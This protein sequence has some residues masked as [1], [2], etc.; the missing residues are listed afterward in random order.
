[1]GRKGRSALLSPF[2]WKKANTIINRLY[3]PVPRLPTVEK[4]KVF[5]PL[6]YYG[7]VSDK[8]R[9]ALTKLVTEY[10]P[11]INLHLAF[12]NRNTI[13]SF[14]QIKNPI[15]LMQRSRVVYKYTCG[16]CSDTYIGKT[17][18]RLATRV[19]E[20]RGI[21]DRTDKPLA[22]PPFSAIREHM[23]QH[24]V[25]VDP[26]C[27]KI[28]ATSTNDTNLKILE[29][30]ATHQMKPEISTKESSMIVQIL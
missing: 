22:C 13:G 12:R 28:L 7:P 4:A 3:S 18:R 15:P 14:F 30:I 25:A 11:Y 5:I 2:F 6:D 29:T 27:F 10:H 26:R 19:S 24:N 20:H 21:S 16:I 8:L 17:M 1:M 23:Q 9:S